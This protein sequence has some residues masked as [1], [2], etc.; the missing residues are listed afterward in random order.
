MSETGQWHHCALFRQVQTFPD[1]NS[2]ATW[3]N[4][5]NKER[6]KIVF[7]D[8]KYEEAPTLLIVDAHTPKK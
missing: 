2:A 4:D 8:M 6:P 5:N 3:N 7:R 1:G